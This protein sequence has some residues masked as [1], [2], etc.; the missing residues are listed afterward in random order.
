[1]DEPACTVGCAAVQDIPAMLD[2]EKRYFDTCWLSRPDTLKSL[3]TNDPM[4]FRLYKVD[5][6]LK[7]YYGIIPLPY[8]VW[9]KVI[10]GK[11]TEEEAMRYVLPFN[12]PDV[13]LYVYSVIVELAD[14][15]HKAYTRE[16]I[17]DFT[18]QYILGKNRQRSNIKA[19]GAFTVSDGGRRIVERSQ[20]IYKGSFRGKNGLYAH[21][22]VIK[23]E[24]LIKQVIKIREQRKKKCIA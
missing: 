1:M 3:I 22:Y 2:L 11:I 5:K 18:R 4:M 14:H 24:S 19:V 7:G 16:L 13:Y 17:R 6:T 8:E 15:K 10:Q 20:F 9:K 23:R 21:S 12:A